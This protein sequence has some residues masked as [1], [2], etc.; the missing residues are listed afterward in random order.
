MNAAADSPRQSPMQTVQRLGR[1]LSSM[2]MPNIGAYIA[3]GLLTA[4]FIPSGW[5]PNETLATLVEP[6]V[7]Y[8]LPLL[9]GYT[10]GKV[11]YGQRGAVLGAVMTFGA[12]VGTSTPLIFGAMVTGPLAA[13]L[14]RW[15]DQ[16]VA[17]R[18]PS[19]FEMLVNN[20]AGGILGCVLASVALLSIGPALEFASLQ[21]GLLVQWVMDIGV[22]PLT[23]LVIEPAK[24]LFLNNVIN[25]GVLSPLAIQQAVE[26]GKSII[27]LLETNPGPGLGVLLAYWAFAKG[28]ARQSAPGAILI[29]FFGGIHEIY[30]PYI[31]MQPKL[32]LA[33]IAGGASGTFVFALLGAGLVAVPSPGSILAV[34]A[35]TP[36]DGL[37]PVLAGLAVSTLVSFAV[38]ALL[39]NRSTIDSDEVLTQA[40]NQL[41]KLKGTKTPIGHDAVPDELQSLQDIRLIAVACDAGMGSSALGASKLRAIFCERAIDVKVISCPIEQL[42]ST[43]DLVIT[44]ERLTARA[45]SKLPDAAHIAISNFMHTPVYEEL[46]TRLKQAKA[47]SAQPAP[48]E[49]DADTQILPTKNIKLGLKSMPRPDAIRLAGSLL[50]DSGCVEDSYIDAMLERENDLSTYIGNGAAIPHGTCAA[51]DKILRSG[52]AVLQFPDGIDFDDNK[53]HLLVA[54]AALGDQHLQILSQLARIFDNAEEMEILRTTTDP[55]Y[56]L[57]T[58][59]GQTQS[60]PEF[61]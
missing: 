24:V 9:I 28:T 41:T 48:A 17:N 16:A 36:N 55:D 26:S 34:L 54:I 53:A 46:A 51:R 14:I 6:M 45:V 31:L 42:A 52:I 35:M 39:I 13:W 61:E 11:V 59:T 19:G 27:F 32:I 18:V 60:S 22:L 43:V 15:F 8:L 3:W 37:L 38:A 5:L 2:I 25:H 40:K 50:R 33:V 29:H 44:H 4:L 7:I 12:I 20:F 57:A 58:F 47:P 10:G 23:A 56:I 21:C 49:L 1:L 30:F